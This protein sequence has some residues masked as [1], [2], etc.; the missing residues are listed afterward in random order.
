VLFCNLLGQLQFGLSDEQHAAW[1][2]AFR[3]RIVPELGG[4]RWA[5]FHDR[6][7][8][9]RSSREPAL[10]LELRF[11]QPPTD[12]QLG[13][14]LFGA[15]DAKVEVLDHGT[16]GLFAEVAAR[17]YFTWQLTPRALHVVEALNG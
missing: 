11:D 2:A 1:C 6:W 3:R 5:S 15:T 9:D 13:T 12:D 17:R 16:S 8:M 7:S 10:P 14:A 4:R